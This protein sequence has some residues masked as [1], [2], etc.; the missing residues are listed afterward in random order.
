VIGQLFDEVVKASGELPKNLMEK[1][2]APKHKKYVEEEG[3]NSDHLEEQYRKLMSFTKSTKQL[4][5]SD[6][7]SCSSSTSQPP[8]FQNEFLTYK[9]HDNFSDIS[10]H[11]Q[12]QYNHKLNNLFVSYNLSEGEICSGII[13]SGKK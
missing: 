12:K 11:D 5:T 3:F 6:L 9:N 13:V 8:I 7:S 4:K 2:K 10:C 1:P